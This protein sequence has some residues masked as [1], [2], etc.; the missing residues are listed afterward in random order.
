MALLAVSCATP[1]LWDATNPNL[2]VKASADNISTNELAAKGIKYRVGKVS[3]D[4]YI[5]K[6]QMR[7]M[8]DYTIRVL[9]TPVAATL[10]AAGGATI[11][12]G[13]IL[14]GEMASQWERS[15]WENPESPEPVFFN[16]PR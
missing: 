14:V 3:G 11:F 1:A 13:A 5:P 8:G 4:I 6:S 10:D 7:K 9:G 16:P 2:Y 15:V 12:V